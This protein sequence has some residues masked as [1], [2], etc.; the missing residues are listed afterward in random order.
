MNYIIKI[1]RLLSREFMNSE[2]LIQLIRE[3]R[4]MNRYCTKTDKVSGIYRESES[5]KF[6]RLET[7]LFKL[8]RKNYEEKM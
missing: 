8:I 4:G 1:K 6:K 3:Y 2:Q 5:Q 7:S